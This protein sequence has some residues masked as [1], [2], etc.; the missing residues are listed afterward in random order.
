MKGW[1]TIIVGI[2]ALLTA[3]GA[4]LTGAMELSDAIKAAFAALA[5]IFA[6]RKGNTM[7]EAIKNGK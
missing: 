6:A 5:V 2:A 7:I 4:Y 3:V 1:G